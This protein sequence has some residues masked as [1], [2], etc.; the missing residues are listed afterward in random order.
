MAGEIYQ[1]AGPFLVNLDGIDRMIPAGTTVRAGH[2][3]LAGREHMFRPFAV[4]FEY[5]PPPEQEG[6]RTEP[7]TDPG[8]QAPRTRPRTAPK[9]E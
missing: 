6:H 9:T 3:L 8:K 4:D 1:A 7:E 2:P 5:E